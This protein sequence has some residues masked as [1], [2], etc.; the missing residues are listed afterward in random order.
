MTRDDITRDATEIGAIIT[1][2][3]EAVRARNLDGILADRSDD[4][5]MFDVPPPT[6]LRGIR[7][8]GKS[9]EEL[10]GWFG[11]TGTFEVDDVIV[12]AGGEVAF[13][14]A[15]IHCSGE[16]PKEG[17]AELE[18]RLTL[19]LRKSGGRWKVVHEHHSVPAP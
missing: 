11:E 3:A 2:W 8:Y 1:R 14:T 19:G 7:A 6:Q 18:V 10:F 4:I 9:W 15:L 17:K 16:G 5:L 13:A 12:H